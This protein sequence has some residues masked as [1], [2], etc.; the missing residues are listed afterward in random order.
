MDVEANIGHV[1]QVLAGH[2]PDNLADFAIRI[3]L[4]ETGVAQG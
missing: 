2:Q 1:V 3:V 4:G